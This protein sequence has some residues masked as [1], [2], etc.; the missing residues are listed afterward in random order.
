MKQVG[1]TIRLHDRTGNIATISLVVKKQTLPE[2]LS[3]NGKTYVLEISD[4][5]ADIHH[6]RE[7]VPVH[8]NEL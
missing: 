5:N 4:D 3:S 7:I 8:I 1:T 2:C 6:Y